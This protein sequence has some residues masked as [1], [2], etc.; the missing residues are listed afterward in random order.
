MLDAVAAHG[1]QVTVPADCPAQWLK[2]SGSSND[3]PQQ[4]DVTISA[5]KLT[6]VGTG[7]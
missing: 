5:L 7:G 4:S 2:L 1:W 6:K 3:L